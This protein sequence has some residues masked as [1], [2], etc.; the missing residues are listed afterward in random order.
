VQ[1]ES[2]ASPESAN[3]HF[4]IFIKASLQSR[5]YYTGLWHFKKL[6]GPIRAFGIDEAEQLT[7]PFAV[8]LVRGTVGMREEHMDPRSD[9]LGLLDAVEL[10]PVVA[11]EY[12]LPVPQMDQQK[13]CRPRGLG[14]DR[15]GGLQRLIYG[16]IWKEQ[17]IES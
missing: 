10:R 12:D 6:L 13:L 15:F 9:L 16:A 8:G 11:E 2:R 4:L 3:V 1:E 7:L 5:D 14:K 17:P